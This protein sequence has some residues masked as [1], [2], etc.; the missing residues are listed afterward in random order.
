MR[1]ADMVETAECW[2]IA[3]L[4]RDRPTLLALSRQATAGL[5]DDGDENRSIN[6]AYVLLDAEGPEQVRIF[7]TGSELSI[8]VEARKLLSGQGIDAAVVSIPCFALFEEADADYRR[9]VI[10]PAGRLKV[11]IEAG[12]RHG[13]DSVIGP[14]GIFVGM[15]GFGA[16]APAPQL[17]KH[18]NITPE[19]VAGAVLDRLDQSG[20]QQ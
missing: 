14:D 13:W 11:G 4:E 7:A 15:S 1:P 6:G 20:N 17:Y 9:G 2:Q 16:S 19:A 10:G 3:L 5:R 8:A 12:V 18:F